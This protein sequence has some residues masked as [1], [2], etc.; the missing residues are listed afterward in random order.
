MSKTSETGSERGAYTQDDDQT[1]KH[2]ASMTIETEHGAS[3]SDHG[4]L[5]RMGKKTVLKARASSNPQMRAIPLGC[6]AR[7][8]FLPKVSQLYHWYEFLDSLKYFSRWHLIE[9]F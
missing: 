2:I 8:L 4:A 5:S 1:G 3:L 6:N 9:C 7:S